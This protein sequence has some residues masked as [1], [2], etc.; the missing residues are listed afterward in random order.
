MAQS[1]ASSGSPV[2]PESAA[3]PRSASSTDPARRYQVQAVLWGNHKRFVVRDTVTDTTIAIRTTSEVAD[4]DLM[5]LNMAVQDRPAPPTT[6][7]EPDK[8]GA[9]VEL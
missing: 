6:T 2:P 9:G 3:P 8:T 7:L 1:A 5:R 4:S